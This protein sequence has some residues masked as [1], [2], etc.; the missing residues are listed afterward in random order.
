MARQSAPSTPPR[1]RCSP[2]TRRLN[3]PSLPQAGAHLAGPLDAS[4]DAK[5]TAICQGFTVAPASKAAASTTSAADSPRPRRRR[6]RRRVTSR[7]TPPARLLPSRRSRSG[8]SSRRRSRRWLAWTSRRRRSHS[9]GELGRGKLEG[10]DEEEDPRGRVCE[11]EWAGASGWRAA[12]S[13]YFC[14]ARGRG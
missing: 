3:F 7:C 13:R 4:F 10:D 9:V 12:P 11:R 14:L 1:T 8:S 5:L 6:P 2:T